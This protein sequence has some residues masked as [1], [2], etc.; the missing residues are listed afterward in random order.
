MNINVNGEVFQLE[1][2]GK[3][4]YDTIVTMAGHN[5]E[6][7]FSVTYHTRRDGDEQRSGILAPGDVT[8][9][10]EGMVFNVADTSHA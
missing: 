5:A 4:D 3:V 2:D 8:K 1:G 9:V 10:E 6:H 7:V